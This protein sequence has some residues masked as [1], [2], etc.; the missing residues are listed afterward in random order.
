MDLGP[1]G[2]PVATNLRIDP[3]IRWIEP[4]PDSML[5]TDPADIAI[6]RE[7]VRLALVAALQR[8]PARQ[9]AALLMHDV[10]RWEATEIALLLDTSTAA[11]NSGLQRA[12][13][14]LARANCS[15]TDPTPP[16]SSAERDLLERYVSAFERYDFEALTSLIRDDAIQSMPPY[17]LWLRGRD[18][19]F[20]WWTGP[21]SACRGSRLL[22]TRGANGC[23]AYAQY[24]PGPDGRWHAW[25]LQV[26]GLVEGR[27]GELTFFLDV[28]RLFPVFGLPP[29]LEAHDR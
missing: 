25:A 5:A 9:R 19:M 18:A 24:K 11:I 8:L 7:S 14:T 10:L 28:E 20:A 27:I 1:A 23:P 15:A 29:R 13:A 26:V 6:G 2:E 17:D 16:L 4:I 22:A 12:R 3:E 21:G